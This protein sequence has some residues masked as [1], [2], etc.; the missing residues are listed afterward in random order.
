MYYKENRMKKNSRCLMSA[1]AAM[2]ALSLTII[3]LYETNVLLEGSLCGD[4][5]TE[6]IAVMLMELVT[7]CALPVALRM[8]CFR[9]VRV[10]I[11]RH[12]LPGHLR[13]AMLRLMILTIPMV[14]NVLCYYLF[15][16][17]AFAY[18][19]VILAISLV[20]ILPTTER[21]ESEQ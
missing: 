13:M 1:L 3:I 12:G 21:C 17:V 7:I 19:A 20:F 8:F 2:V 5:N 10:Y 11:E 14:A 4:A 6:F 18:L 9:V 15:M 16:K